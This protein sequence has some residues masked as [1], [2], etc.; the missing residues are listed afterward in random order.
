MSLFRYLYQPHISLSI[1]SPLSFLISFFFFHT[2]INSTS[3]WWKIS[4]ETWYIWLYHASPYTQSQSKP[5]PPTTNSLTNIYLRLYFLPY[6]SFIYRPSPSPFNTFIFS[7]ILSISSFCLD[8][9]K[10]KYIFSLKEFLE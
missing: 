3:I 5:K 9:E 2:K 7:I 6:L 4:D 1:S 10:L 8:V